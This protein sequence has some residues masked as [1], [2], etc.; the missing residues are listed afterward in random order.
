MDTISIPHRVLITWIPP[1]WVSSFRLQPVRTATPR[2]TANRFRAVGH[3]LPGTFSSGHRIEDEGAISNGSDRV[4]VRAASYFKGISV[5]YQVKARK[6]ITFGAI[7]IGL[8]GA[9]PRATGPICI[10]RQPP[11]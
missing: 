4:D 2:R 1:V 5:M 11:F 8:A 6:S 10:W 7:P 9:G 3:N